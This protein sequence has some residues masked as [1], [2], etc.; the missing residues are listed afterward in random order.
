MNVNRHQAFYLIEMENTLCVC[1][2]ESTRGFEYI[3]A[4]TFYIYFDSVLRTTTSK[5]CYSYHFLHLYFS[6]IAHFKSFGWIYPPG[7][8]HNPKHNI[9]NDTSKYYEKFVITFSKSVRWFHTIFD[10]IQIKCV[11]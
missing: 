7:K 3:L 4:C 8:I 2:T 9:I 11:Y 6:C 5:R 10:Q 1:R